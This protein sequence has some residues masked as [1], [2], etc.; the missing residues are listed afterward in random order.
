MIS[1]APVPTGFFGG[2]WAFGCDDTPWLE[3]LHSAGAV[4]CMD[5]LGAHYLLG[6]TSPSATSGHP[7]DSGDGYHAWYFLPQTQVYRQIFQER[8]IFYTEM[9]YAS[10]EGVSQ[11]HDSFAWARGNTD[12]EQAAWLAEAVQLSI[13][14]RMVRAIMVW[15][16]D[17]ER[18]GYDPRDG[19]AIIRP[20]G[21][22]PAC[23]TLHAVLGSR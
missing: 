8:Q 6:A 15:N 4:Q 19:Y 23:E 7:A 20:G 13:D 3:G 10:Q 21:I 5:Y 9:G 2:C 22:C 14:T 17:F 11:F 18:V 12:A 16:I 1:A